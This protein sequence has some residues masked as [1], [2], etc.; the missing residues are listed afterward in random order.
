VKVVAYII[1]SLTAGVAGIIQASQVHTAAV[2]YGMGIEL[3]V[4]AAV[5]LGGTS[6]AG[7]SGS[8]FLTV[9]GV[10]LIGVVNN[11]LALLNVPIEMQL[12]AKGIIIVLALAMANRR[13]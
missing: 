3:D 7:G 9:V 5:V 13:S 6:L 4:I 11:G 10:L 12:L 2:T 1:C 8:V